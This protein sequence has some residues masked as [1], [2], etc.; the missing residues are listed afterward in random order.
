MFT[1]KNWERYNSN[2]APIFQT[3]REAEREATA[4]RAMR[5]WVEV[6]EIED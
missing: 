6:V 2:P 5:A 3:R 1:L 4:L